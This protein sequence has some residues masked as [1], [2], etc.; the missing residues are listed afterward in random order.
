MKEL[1]LA[2]EDDEAVGVFTCPV[3]ASQWTSEDDKRRSLVTYP[4][5]DKTFSQLVLESNK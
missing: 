4:C 3:Q 5:L 2:K 1:L